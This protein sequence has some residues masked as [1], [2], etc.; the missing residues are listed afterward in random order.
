MFTV[1]TDGQSLRFK[2]LKT[3]TFLVFVFIVTIPPG[4]ENHYKK[5]FKA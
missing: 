4:E 5:I 1:N 3:H 2:A